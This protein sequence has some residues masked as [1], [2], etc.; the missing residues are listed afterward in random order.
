MMAQASTGPVEIALISSD[1]QFAAVMRAASGARASVKVIPDHIRNSPAVD[2]DSVRAIIVD[3]DARNHADLVSLQGFMSRVAGRVPVVVV[4]ET[5]DDAVARWF[6]QI[7]VAD[8]LRKPVEPSEAIR[9]CLKALGGAQVGGGSDCRILSFLPAAGGVG[10]TTLAIETAMLL[11]QAG[12]KS[13]RAV[14]LVD[15]DFEQG[16]C[17]DYLDLEPRLDLGEILPHP[18]RLDM[19]LLEVMLSRHASGLVVL[20]APQRPADL[21]QVTPDIVMR[22]LDLV[23]SRFDNVV[24]DMPRQWRPW[25]DAVLAGSNRVYVV[26]DMTV[27]GLRTGRRVADTINARLGD[28]LV[29][30]AQVIVNRFEQTLLF[31]NGLRRADVERVFEGVLAGTVSNNYKLVREAIDRGVALDEVKTGNPVSTDLRRIVQSLLDEPATMRAA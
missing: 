17:V 13:G 5:F 23:S 18:E 3:I 7:R 9:S 8:F 28:Q 2:F 1:P 25:S 29:N 10:V 26:T 14:C 31:G 27:P 22:L 24:V 16:A 21:C 19:Q 15:L 11:N 4:T 12:K 6:L 20:A 30:P